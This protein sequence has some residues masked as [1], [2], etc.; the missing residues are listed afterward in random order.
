MSEAVPVLSRTPSRRVGEGALAAAG[1]VWLP[2]PVAC[3]RM[4]STGTVG[5]CGV[6][7]GSGV[8]DNI[9][10]V[11]GRGL[12]AVRLGLEAVGACLQPG[13]LCFF[14]GTVPWR[15]VLRLLCRTVCR[16]P[17]HDGTGPATRLVRC[18]TFCGLR[19]HA[20]RHRMG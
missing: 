9:R 19:L 12:E 4:P 17:G 18:I 2:R 10:V 6:R 1:G 3:A 16:L 14:Q 20:D 11:T 5:M 15:V 8:G 13:N 7:K